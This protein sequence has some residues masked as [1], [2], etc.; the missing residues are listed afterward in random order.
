[1]DKNVS[2]E[3]ENQALN[4]IRNQ[5]VHG[6]VSPSV[7]NP[8][9]NPNYKAPKEQLSTSSSDWNTRVLL[10]EMVRGIRLIKDIAETDSLVQTVEVPLF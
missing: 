10:L 1:M 3:K 7:P 6:G 9:K 2:T 5:V 8:L 4:Y